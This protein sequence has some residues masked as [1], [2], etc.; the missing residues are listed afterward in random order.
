[1]RQWPGFT[2]RPGVVLPDPVAVFPT[3]S[4]GAAGRDLAAAIL[5]GDLDRAAEM[6]R[7]DRRLIA[8]ATPPGVTAPGAV[9]DLLTLAVCRGD[10]DA[11]RLLLDAGMPPD[12][13]HRGA[14]L[15]LALLADTPELA[16]IL[17]DAGASPDPQRVPGGVDVIAAMI[18][19]SHVGGV[20]ALLRH[21]A[22]PHWT[23][24]FGID[25]VRAAVDA[26]QLEIAELFGERGASFW[27]IA[28]D[29][30]TAAHLVS[31]APAV[32]ATVRDL[33]I[34]RRLQAALRA[35]AHRAG[36][37]WPP[38]SPND[39]RARLL[40]GAWPTPAMVAIG[41][42]APP[43]GARADPAGGWSVAGPGMSA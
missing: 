35:Q 15:V 34:R 40:A 8:T 31:A 21:G 12:G 41:F 10:G 2:A 27:T 9:A 20:M 32:F 16:T 1:M 4:H 42:V 17:L 19:F 39:I 18:A 7:R 28:R 24:G 29:G 37:P 13:V 26:E 23:D 36:L 5:A 3:L 38:P 6:V 25:R 43:G 33:A 11:I 22:D 14:A 30:S